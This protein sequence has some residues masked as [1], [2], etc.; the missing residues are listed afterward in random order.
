LADNG[1]RDG[2]PLN[3]LP[4]YVKALGGTAATIGLVGFASM[5]AHALV[6][7]PGGILG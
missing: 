3:I 1:L 6:Q 4:L 7:F 2:D 5:I